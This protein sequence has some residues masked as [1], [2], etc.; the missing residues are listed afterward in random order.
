M[1]KESK[2]QMSPGAIMAAI[3]SGDKDLN[4]SDFKNASEK[5]FSDRGV[6]VRIDEKGK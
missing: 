4:M 2:E 3:L 5:F 6:N 1:K